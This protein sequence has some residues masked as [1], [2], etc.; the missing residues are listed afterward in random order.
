MLKVIATVVRRANISH[1]EL[2]NVWEKVHAPHV[3]KIAQPVHYRITFFDLQ[4]TPDDPGLDGMAEL[5]FRDKRHFETTI[6]RQAPPEIM[7]DHFNEYADFNK[8]TWLSVTEHINID[9]LTTRETTKLIYFVKRREGIERSALDKYWL[10]THIPNVAA[11]LRRTPAARRYTVDL[12][13]P[14]RERVYDGIAQISMDGPH[15]SFAD[16]T[17]YEPD[18]FNELVQPLLMSRGH[19]IR[20]V[21]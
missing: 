21:E 4:H 6:G 18:Q 14:A 3:V 13:D 11:A 19:E 8:G 2:V 15:P 5:W 9:G 1:D 17:S 10:E 16:V 12:V 7:N 20:I